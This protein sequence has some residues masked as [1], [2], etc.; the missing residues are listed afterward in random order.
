MAVAAAEALALVGPGDAFVVSVLWLVA[1]E[2][3]VE[4]QATARAVRARATTRSM[5][6][7]CSGK[8]LDLTCRQ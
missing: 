6:M 2:V 7:K 5:R 1:S 4:V 8:E 3:A